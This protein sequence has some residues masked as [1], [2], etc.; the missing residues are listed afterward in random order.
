MFIAL[1]YMGRDRPRFWALGRCRFG[2]RRTGY[3]H[4]R[5]LLGQPD[6]L[7]HLHTPSIEIMFGKNSHCQK[8]GI[9]EPTL[10]HGAFTPIT[11]RGDPI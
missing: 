6:I 4:L 1:V 9:M 3:V 10:I 2:D 5:L 8:T 7:S 11:H